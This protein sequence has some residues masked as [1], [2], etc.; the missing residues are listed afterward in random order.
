M[1]AQSLASRNDFGDGGAYHTS[2]AKPGWDIFLK[3]WLKALEKTQQD[4]AD[5]LE[6]NKA[7]VSLIANGKQPYSRDDVNQ[8]AEF[9]NLRPHEL[10]MHPDDAFA[11]RR[12]KAEMIR[13]AHENEEPRSL[14]DPK[15][16]SLN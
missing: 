16:V 6:W 14:D 3:Q 4:V 9:L 8:L 13:L 12:L 11:I 2:M 15:K 7:K 1:Q 5:G 10:L